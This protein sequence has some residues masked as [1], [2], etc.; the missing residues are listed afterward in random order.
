MTV[1]V[2]LDNNELNRKF[3][4]FLL[5]LGLCNKVQYAD[6]IIAADADKCYS[7]FPIWQKHNISP[8][9]GTMMYLI[10]KEKPYNSVARVT[11]S[12]VDWVINHYE[13]FKDKFKQ[14][15]IL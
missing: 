4:D 2:Q 13:E 9:C 10:T 14:I 5:L 7:Y 8:I 6:A 15:G 11:E 1:Q 3:P 12:P